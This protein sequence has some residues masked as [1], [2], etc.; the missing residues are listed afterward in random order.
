MQKEI[1]NFA[2]VQKDGRGIDLAVTK[3][4]GAMNRYKVNPNTLIM[5]AEMELY[6]TKVPDERINYSIAGPAGPATFA[7]GPNGIRNGTFNGLTVYTADSFDN[8]DGSEAT[9]LLRRNTQVGEAYR[10][11]A[12]NS[13]N[14]SLGCPSDYMDIIIYDEQADRLQRITFA[15]ALK[16]AL[17]RRGNENKVNPGWGA[18]EECDGTAVKIDN[19]YGSTTTATKDPAVACRELGR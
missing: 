10:M 16:Y 3:A 7:A 5:P 1:V 8:G 17:A 18:F 15:D 11:R 4:I 12:P 13:W 19:L 2:V 6:I 14:L 9:Q